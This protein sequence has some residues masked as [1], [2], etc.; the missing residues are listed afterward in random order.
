[1]NRQE[2]RQRARRLNGRPNAMR[3]IEAQV[4]ALSADELHRRLVAQGIARRA[5]E[6]ALELYW[7][8]Q[9]YVRIA[10]VRRLRGGPDEAL[11]AVTHEVREA[12]GLGM[13]IYR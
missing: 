5:P 3:R 7:V 1:M 6:D 11:A 8:M 9:A 10:K 4:N 13:P 12:T 2:R